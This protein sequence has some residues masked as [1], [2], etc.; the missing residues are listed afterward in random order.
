MQCSRANLARLSKVSRATFFGSAGH[1]W[2][3][4]R[5]LRSPGIGLWPCIA[6]YDVVLTFSSFQCRICYVVNI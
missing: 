4:G 1:F 2:P 3:A 6:D 5:Y